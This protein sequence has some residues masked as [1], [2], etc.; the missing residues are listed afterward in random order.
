MYLIKELQKHEA[1]TDRIKEKIERSTKVA[2][3]STFLSDIDRKARKNLGFK[4]IKQ[5]C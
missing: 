2:D 3:F 5:H 1:K 4:K